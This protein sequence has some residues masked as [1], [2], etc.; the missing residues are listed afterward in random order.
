ML[1]SSSVDAGMQVI[2]ESMDYQFTAHAHTTS[3]GTWQH[4]G[5]A[6]LPPSRR[7]SGHLSGAATIGLSRSVHVCV[8]ARVHAACS[9]QRRVLRGF[10]G[11]A[12]AGAQLLMAHTPAAHGPHAIL[13]GWP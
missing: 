6:H 8:G 1:I 7:P 3:Y 10:G 12:R 2:D 5:H 11:A 13:G 4:T 9:G